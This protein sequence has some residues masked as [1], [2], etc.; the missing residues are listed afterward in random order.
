MATEAAPQIPTTG[1]ESSVLIAPEWVDLLRVGLLGGA[2]GILI[3]AL[4]W[5]LQH[6]LI[7]PLFC[8]NTSSLAMCS[9]SDL[10]TYY[11]STVI[12]GVIA[13][14][15]MAN[16]QVFRPLLIAVAAAAALW[17]FQR[18]V[19]DTVSHAGFEYYLSSAI[20]YALVFLLFYWILRFKSFALSVTLTILAVVLIRWALLS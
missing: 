7:T 14:A 15:L 4:G 17:G 5:L 10:T 3:P 8:H 12:L 13:V 2:V 9:A 6:F 16:W 1:D 18:Y 11:I 19:G 20:L